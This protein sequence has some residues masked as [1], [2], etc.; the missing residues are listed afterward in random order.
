MVSNREGFDLAAIAS[1][2]DS[3][4]DENAQNIVSA[5]LEGRSFFQSTAESQTQIITGLHQ[6]TR[7]TVIHELRR[8]RSILIGALS[9]PA[10]KEV[11]YGTHEV[12]DEFA[13]EDCILE[14]LLFPSISERYKRVTEA[15]ANTYKWIFMDPRPEDRPWSSFKDWLENGSGIYWYVLFCP[16]FP[17]YV[18]VG[19]WSHVL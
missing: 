10:S 16:Y 6:E 7:K 8:T 2:M 14:S 4:L 19:S 17:V 5:L 3:T 18:A 11:S 1:R 13:A 15:H 9:K 12:S